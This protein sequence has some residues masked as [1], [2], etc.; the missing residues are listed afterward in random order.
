MVVARVI[1]KPKREESL[2][3]FHPWIFSGAIAQ[4]EGSPAEGDVVAVHSSKGEP[5]AY[6]HY[7]VGSIR[8]RILSFGESPINNDFWHNRFSNAYSLRRQLG[9][10]DSDQT[11]AYRLV[12]GEGDFLPG[13][14]VDIYG[15]TAVIQAHSAGMYR[16]KDIIV[17]S[18]QQLYG[19]RLKAIYDKSAATVPF[20]AG[21]N[22]QDGYLFGKGS[23]TT[24]SEYGKL[25]SI[26]WEE[27]QKT[28][29][30]LDQRENRKL[31]ELYSKDAKALNTFCYTG[32][33]SVYALSGGAKQVDSVDSSK[34]A[35]ELTDTNVRLNF[36]DTER[37]RSF[38]VDTF[39]FLR[40]NTYTYDIIVLDP[41]AFAKHQSALRNALQAYKRL[42]IAALAGLNRGGLLFTFSCSQAVNREAFQ[43]AVF[44][45]AAIS[46][47]NVRIIHRLGQ[48][49]DHPVSIYHPEGDYLKGLVL[50][51]E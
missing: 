39:D 40:E 48:P 2:L 16:S 38:A 49:A 50:Q 46:K 22:A 41:P 20:K 43:N 45:A 3:R 6:G 18:L 8:I 19:S 10:T 42:N 12:H 7:Q 29:F 14:V 13:L 5:L 47:R 37:H 26:D 51:V 15:D 36:G 32:G 28:G 11:T 24:V 25:F 17:Q 35:I 30:F 23:E 1:L 9:L 4:L 21:L 44:S 33:F 34:K 31:L 27:G